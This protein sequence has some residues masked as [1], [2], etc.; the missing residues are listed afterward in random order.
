MSGTTLVSSC[1]SGFRLREFH[2]LRLAFPKPF[3]Y[4]STIPSGGP[5]PRIT[6]YRF[7]LFPVRSP[8][9]WEIDVSFFSWS[10]LDVS[11]PRFLHAALSFSSVACILLQVGS[12]IRISAVHSGYLLLPAAFRS[13]SRT[14]SAP[15]A[16]AS[17][18][19]SRQ[20]LTV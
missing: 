6:S 12:A 19:R 9:L 13:L 1:L 10:Y 20:F 4:P 8:L 16:K 17:A 3:D 5:Q 15:S 14:S 2:P 18:L 7:G 11:S